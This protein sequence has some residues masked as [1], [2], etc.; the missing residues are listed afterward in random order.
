[1]TKRIC[2]LTLICAAV[3]SA[4]AITFS[5]LQPGLTGT[6][7][8]ALTFRYSVTNNSGGILYGLAI[9]ADPFSDGTPDASVFDAFGSGIANGATL[10]GRLFAFAADPLV[11]NSF[12]S[13]TF[14]LTVLLADGI[15]TQDLFANYSVTIQSGN[16]PEPGV[17]WLMVAGLLVL[18]TMRRFAIG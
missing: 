11:A 10:T 15:T 12:N 17:G 7:G 13:G 5:L 18:A 1:M 8:S 4:D 9:N 16:A 14:D 2:L 3:A 6:P